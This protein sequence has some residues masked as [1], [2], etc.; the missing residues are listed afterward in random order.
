MKK[1]ILTVACGIFISG[2]MSCTTT[3]PTGATGTLSI[4]GTINNALQSGVSIA[5]QGY[6]AGISNVTV[7]AYT[8][9]AHTNAV[10]SSIVNC[11]GLLLSG[12]VAYTISGLA[13]GTY[14]LNAVQ[15][16]SY[17]V[18]GLTVTIDNTGA[19]TDTL[20]SNDL[21]GKNIALAVKTVP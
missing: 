4:A 15:P 21:T 6:S 9:S 16:V 13:K 1:T 14:Y 17:S 3:S 12:N 19:A 7:T 10:A 5:Y 8:D 18:S 2:M 20:G 11:S